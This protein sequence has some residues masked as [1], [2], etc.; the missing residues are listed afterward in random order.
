VL[1]YPYLDSIGAIVLSLYIIKEWTETLIENTRN[2]TGK[3][4]SPHA[5]Q[6][7][8]YLITRFSPLVKGVQHV[9]VR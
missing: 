1:H 5:H 4:A 7:V 2:L 6:R 9:E 3:R 8:C